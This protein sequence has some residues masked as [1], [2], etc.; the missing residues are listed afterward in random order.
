MLAIVAQ[1]VEF[2]CRLCVWHCYC[3]CAN[4]PDCR[5]Y[6]DAS[7]VSMYLSPVNKERSTGLDTQ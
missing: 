6:E 4:A 3:D 2:V 5:P 7:R 1:F